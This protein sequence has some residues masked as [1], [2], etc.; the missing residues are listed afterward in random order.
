[1]RRL[2]DDGLD[3]LAARSHEGTAVRLAVGVCVAVLAAQLIAPWICVLWVGVLV[4]NEGLSWPITRRQFKGQKAGIRLRLAHL[5]MLA[6][7]CTT[8]MVLG[9]ALWTT[10]IAEGQVV[11]AILW[12][13]V[14]YFTETNAYQSP[15]GFIV[16]G[17]IPG[18]A[19]LAWLTV[20]PNPA[21]LHM[22]PV[23][24]MLV[25]AMVF[26][27][28]GVF[29]ALAA[30]RQFDEA[31]ARL[32]ASE[33]QYRVLADNV[34][35]VIAL[36][37]LDGRRIY[38]SPS[39]E[40]AM[41]YSPE[42]LFRTQNYTFLHP[43]D[44]DWVPRE[45]AR[46]A[47]TGG[48]MTQ[49]YRIVHRDGHPVW[50]ETN[51]GI[52]PGEGPD[53]ETMIISVSRNIDSRVALEAELTE[54]RRR[55]EAAAAAKSDFL[56][57]MTHELRTPLNAIIGFSGILGRSDRLGPE[58][59]RH[60]RL[61]HDASQSLLELVNDVLDFSKLE[62]GAAELEAHPFDPAEIAAS[63]TSLLADQALGRGLDLRLEVLGQTRPVM[64]DGARIRQVL[65]NFL[66]NAMK[67]TN[68]G[69]V[70][71]RMEQTPAGDAG[72]RLRVEV[73][74]TGIGVAP[75]QIGHLFDRFTQADA[76]VSRRY[77]G[78]G[79]GLAICKRNIELMGGTLG[80]DSQPGEGSTF[81]FELTLPLAEDADEPVAAPSPAPDGPLRLLV[82]ED[83]AVN[84]EL[85]QTLLAPFDIA[86]ETAENGVQAVERM[87]HGT[88]DI[89][90][91]DIQMPI[92]D[93]L[94]ATRAIRALPQA[95][96]RTIPIIAMTANVLPEQVRTCLEAGM[97]DHLGK[98]ISPATLLE[99]LSRW[100]PAS[101]AAPEEAT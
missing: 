1:M 100:A 61:I 25:L 40:K 37:S 41:G 78:T 42:E 96:A 77:G 90:L 4:L 55:A 92:M 71:V 79:L 35:D 94:S 26:A 52:I 46:L 68:A 27:S 49:R 56:A 95:Q 11:A 57:N 53:A 64:G 21:H 72:D 33:A 50:V 65:M 74:D 88:F 22:L 86:I 87:T 29:R 19:L 32:K 58:D 30:R 84:R 48:Q 3:E 44:A 36:N 62:A 97:N 54:A 17:A 18:L 12:L 16:G 10:G 81:W 89:V 47:Q 83:V 70:G 69:S 34:S 39:I 23:I 15:I 60:A 2:L 80:V 14:L 99:T 101:E 7:G 28:D 8:W 20:A 63:V 24:G 75:D 5:F 51:F 45:L 6:Q 59:A 9:G 67:F 31:Q 98:P 66:S 91:M 76:S 43:D 93:G 13:S 73:T 85:I 82:V 38:L